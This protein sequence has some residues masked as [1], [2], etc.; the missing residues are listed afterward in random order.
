MKLRH[1]AA[2]A[3]VGWYLMLPPTT[4]NGVD[5]SAPLAQW[6]IYQEYD[7]YRNCVA[8]WS[9]LQ[10]Q[11]KPD[12]QLQFPPKQLRQFAAAQCVSSEDSDLKSN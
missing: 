7:S 1:A 8:G 9:E 2:L 6:S 11:T 10:N 4:L 12:A 5:I 3:L